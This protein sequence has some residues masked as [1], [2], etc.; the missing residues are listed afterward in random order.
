[1]FI[2]DFNNVY[3]GIA[4]YNISDEAKRDLVK[5]YRNNINSDYEKMVEIYSEF[6]DNERNELDSYVRKLDEMDISHRGI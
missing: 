5:D 2:E 4:E 1:M 6:F 3:E